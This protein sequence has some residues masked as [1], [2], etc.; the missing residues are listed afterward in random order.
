MSRLSELLAEDDVLSG[1]D[2][3]TAGV[4]AGFQSAKDLQ[5]KKE[6]E[7]EAA[8]DKVKA[9]HQK[10]ATQSI[11]RLKDD[12]DDFVSA[13]FTAF[14]KMQDD[15]VTSLL[16]KYPTLDAAKVAYKAFLGIGNRLEALR[17]G[18]NVSI[19]KK[20]VQKDTVRRWQRAATDYVKSKKS[21]PNFNQFVR[22][23]ARF[24]KRLVTVRDDFQLDDA[25][26]KELLAMKINQTDPTRIID[27]GEYVNQVLM[28]ASIAFLNHA[29]IILAV[30]ENLSDE[31]AEAEK[32]AR[33]AGQE[34]PDSNVKESFSHMKALLK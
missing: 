21:D 34:T 18:F 11:G 26:F 14:P 29:K 33:A 22:N 19:G 27:A 28:M 16:V 17:N 7:L 10:A 13:F 5:K 24:F 30:G 2:K 8:K 15:N 31:K 20:R 1:V 6:D 12:I 32:T 9:A 4:K 3:L 25:K 23:E